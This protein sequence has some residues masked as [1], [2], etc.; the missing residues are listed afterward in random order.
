MQFSVARLHEIKGHSAAIYDVYSIN[1]FIYTA[2]GDKTIVRWILSNGKQD[3]F[4][5]KTDAIP[6]AITGIQQ[7]KRIAFGLNNGFLHLIDVEERKE[8]KCFH[9]HRSAIHRLFENVQK[10]QFYSTDA[11]GNLAV[12]STEKLDLLV[13]LPFACGKIRDVSLSP[14]GT[15]LALAGQDGYIRI[16]DTEF[17]NLLEQFYA[18]DGGVT[19]LVWQT[20]TILISGGKDAY[21]SRWNIESM[22]KLYAFPAHHFVIYHLIISEE[23]LISCSR[24]KTLKFWELDTF[25]PVFKLDT[26]SGGHFYSI[27]RLSLNANQ[28]ISVSDDKHILVHNL[29][30]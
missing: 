30:V 17:Y 13:F 3:N 1:D 2:S 25:K 23:Y 8:I 27:N 4:V 19:S 14:N 18:H 26:K 6:Y 9:Q 29:H 28:L 7:G 15:K 12:W 10:N 20:D 22:A 16:L 24:D 11:E 5:V 21:I